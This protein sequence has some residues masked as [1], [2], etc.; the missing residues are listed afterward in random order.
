MAFLLEIAMSF[1]E[2]RQQVDQPIKIEWMCKI[3]CTEDALT[4]SHDE[5]L[6]GHEEKIKEQ[7]YLCP[8]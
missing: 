4:C 8:G 5:G 3:S 7:K 6:K 1:D 2:A